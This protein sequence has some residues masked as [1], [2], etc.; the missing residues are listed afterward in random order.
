MKAKSLL[1]LLVV[2][3]FLNSQA[4]ENGRQSVLKG[5]IFSADG[6]TE[7]PYVQVVNL[8]RNTGSSSSERGYFSISASIGDSLEFSSIGYE[9][10]YF[11]ITDF[12]PG[13]KIYLIPKIYDLKGVEVNAYRSEK[14]FRQDFV[15][16]R[17]PPED[18]PKINLPT[19][20]KYEVNSGLASRGVGLTFGGPITALYK[21]FSTEAKELRKVEAFQQKYK[22][23]K[24]YDVKYNKDL[25]SKVTGL[26]GEDLD[27]FL[28]F[29]DLPQQFVLA[30]NEYEIVVAINDCMKDFKKDKKD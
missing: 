21:Q 12:D 30:S 14:Q 28:K 26:H 18:K 4:Q 24:V 29:C 8:K 2:F 23:Q 25:I 20:S 13:L 17:I 6:I 19:L 3:C 7:I 16:L 27:L 9:K 15:I 1:F 22:L 5:H 11:E 10:G